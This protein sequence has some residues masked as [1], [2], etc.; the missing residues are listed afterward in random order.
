MVSPTSTENIEF[1]LNALVQDQLQ[2]VTYKLVSKRFN[3][4]Y[5]T[6]KKILYAFKDKNG[7]VCLMILCL[8]F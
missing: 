7:D 8:Y 4:P 1:E 2:A 5:D 6:S 3:I